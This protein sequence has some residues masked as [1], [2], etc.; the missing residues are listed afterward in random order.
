MCAPKKAHV[1]A[2]RGGCTYRELLNS[3]VYRTR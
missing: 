2:A 1:L 3:S